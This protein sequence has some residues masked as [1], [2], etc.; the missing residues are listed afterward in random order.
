M[1]KK[2]IDNFDTKIFEKQVTKLF[3]SGNVDLQK[4]KQTLVVGHSPEIIFCFAPCS[5]KIT[6]FL[7][8]NNFHIIS[9][10]ATYRLR[11]MK[12]TFS[13]KLPAGFEFIK[14]TSEIPQLKIA[15]IKKMA[16]VIGGTS[17]YFR[18]LELP[19]K[20][21]QDLYTEWIFNSLYN[22]Y[23][24][25][26]FCITKNKELVG[27]VTIKIKG[28]CGYIDLL[29]V[30][31]RWHNLGLGSFLMKH[32]LQFLS[33]SKISTVR[34]VTEAENIP[35]TAFYQKMGF[36]VENMELVYHKHVS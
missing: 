14:K 8:E 34:V 28:D 16:V 36:V 35:A 1:F 29:G 20:K 22:G 31:P 15:S 6:R 7:E 19:I 4:I 21:S 3:I 33:K 25:A 10:R 17:R 27:L 13:A 32:A 30:V 24:D 23:A 2:I 11:D 9:S 26:S 5:P 12:R 18:D